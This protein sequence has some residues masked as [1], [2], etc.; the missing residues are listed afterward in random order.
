MEPIDLFDTAY[1]DD[2]K[3]AGM[4]LA[5]RM[6]PKSLED[7]VGQEEILGPGRPLRRGIEN[8]RLTSLLLFG[9]PGCGK[10]TI[11]TIIAGSTKAHF[12]QIS[13]VSSGVADI[14]RIISEAGDRFR[15][16]R[17]R[18]VLFID[19]IHRFNKSQQDALLPAVENGTIILIGATTAN[20]FFEINAA[21]VSRSQLVRLKP[22][23]DSALNKIITRALK[24][25]ENGFGSLQIEL[26]EEAREH[27]LRNSS[28]DARNALN[29]LE[30]AV[31][32]TPANTDGVIHIGSMEMEE[33]IRQKVLRYD[34]DGDQ[35]YDIISA[36]IKSMRGSDPDAAIYWMS[37]MLAAG[38]DPRFIM[39]R[40]MI[41]A[42]EDVGTADSMALQV[43][44]AAAQALEMI[45]LPEAQFAIS[46]A[47]IY[48]ATAPKSNAVNRAMSGAADIVAQQRGFGAV[49]LHLR[50]A[51]YRS[52][53]RLGHGK[54][55]LY[56]HDYPGNFV[57]QQYLPDDLSEERFFF[58]GENCAEKRIAQRLAA[59][60]PDRYEES[61]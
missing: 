52:A 14:K 26:T 8:D 13:A 61:E 19:E 34:K 28:Y 23:D 58:P 17:R 16:Y 24:D 5:A 11:A 59:W 51:S 49:P 9:P 20:P 4:P 36:F 55:Y 44:V 35:H 18:T 54:G 7:L 3:G 39:R 21:L 32:N 2:I 10:T 22:L 46:H 25:Q 60:W 37:R 27:L 42:S 56:A 48:V 29:G 1:M 6:R 12:E 50:D 15:V 31:L 57:R 41:C 40:V 47:V 38:E 45:G 43:A 33:A 30:I 53:V